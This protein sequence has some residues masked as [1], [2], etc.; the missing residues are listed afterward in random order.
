[1]AVAQSDLPFDIDEEFISQNQKLNYKIK[2]RGGGPYTKSERDKRQQEVYRLHF[3]YGYSARKISQLM[4][5]NRNTI[6]GDI[7]YWYLQIEKSNNNFNPENVII[8]NL[9]RL[10]I[11]RSRLREQLDKTKTFQERLALER[12]IYEIDCKILQ[13]HSRVAESSRRLLEFSLEQLNRWLAENKRGER[14]LNMFDKMSVSDKAYEK[15][16]KII[17]EDRLARRIF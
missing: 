8:N 9:Q 10:E 11:Q 2:R 6:N 16:E 1:M 3:E 4:N 14:C 15:I 13:T 12:L 5:V 7:D 17:K